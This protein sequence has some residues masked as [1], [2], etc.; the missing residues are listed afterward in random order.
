VPV[1]NDTTGFWVSCI[2]SLYESDP[3]Q[4]LIVKSVPNAA[5]AASP[6]SL[7]L[8]HATEASFASQTAQTQYRWYVNDTLA[9]ESAQLSY[10]FTRAGLYQICLSTTD[11]IGCRDSVCRDFRVLLRTA[12]NQG[13]SKKPILMPNPANQQVKITWNQPII[14]WEIVN[15]LGEVM[16]EQHFEQAELIEL[17]VKHWPAGLYLLKAKN[18]EGQTVHQKFVKH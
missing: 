3:V 4:V 9:G 12:S 5:F 11:E 10:T 1:L 6:D 13:L 7:I 2:D 17:E 18:P 16:T 15:M 14:S 8:N